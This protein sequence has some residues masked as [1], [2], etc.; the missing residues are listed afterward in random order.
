MLWKFALRDLVIVGLALGLWWL[1]GPYTVG[2]G[3]VTDMLGVVVGLLA[4]VAATV[5]HEWGHLLGALASGST[6]RLSSR[7]GSA[8]SFSFDSHL[9]SLRQ[10]VAMSVPGLVVTA[11]LVWGAYAFLPEGELATR[12]ARGF[13]LV[14]AFLGVVLELP[15]LFYGLITRRVP[16][17]E[18]LPKRRTG[19]LAPSGV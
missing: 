12:V 1:A 8:F 9:N 15:L 6:V 18:A 5:L 16:P 4:G 11:L 2:T 7:L 19:D 3:P 14:L 13:I 10:F 17:L